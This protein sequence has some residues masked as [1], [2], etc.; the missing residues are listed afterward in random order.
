MAPIQEQ[1]QN[2]AGQN[3]P[4][5]IDYHMTPPEAIDLQHQH[6][7]YRMFHEFCAI[8]D[9]GT[10]LRTIEKKYNQ[11]GEFVGLLNSSIKLPPEFFGRWCRFFS[12]EGRT[13]IF[14]MD[15]NQ[16]DFAIIDLD[17]G[18]TEGCWTLFDAIPDGAVFTRV[19]VFPGDESYRLWYSL[20]DNEHSTI[21][22][23]FGFQV[24]H[25][26]ADGIHMPA[27]GI[28]MPAGGIH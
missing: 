2:N 16:R 23:G 7:V 3:L 6:P 14:V 22:L 27:G 13:F 28:H 26:P 4:N 8:T 24:F 11:Q 17:Y 1:Q 19:E 9:L 12:R 18:V 10:Y 5:V 21:E 15:Y 20:D 25:M